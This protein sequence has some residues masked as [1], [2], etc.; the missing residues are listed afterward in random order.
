MGGIITYSIQS[1]ESVLTCDDY[2]W[3]AITMTSTPDPNGITHQIVFY[4][5]SALQ[6]QGFHGYAIGNN[7][8]QYDVYV[9]LYGKQELFSGALATLAAPGT[10]QIVIYFSG[11][12]S[13]IGGSEVAVGW[14]QI[15]KDVTSVSS[16]AVMA[17]LPDEIRKR[18]AVK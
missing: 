8:Q 7:P 2:P 16:A 9:N 10:N 14:A 12:F 6:N 4:F 15:V 17:G 5:F 11:D 1:Y 18:F 13:A 3:G